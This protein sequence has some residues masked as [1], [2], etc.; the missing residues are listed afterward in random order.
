MSDLKCLL[1]ILDNPNLLTSRSLP[2]EFQEEF[3][4]FF[5][6]IGNVMHTENGSSD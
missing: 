4:Y 2:P 6:S 3:E 5:F 1:Q